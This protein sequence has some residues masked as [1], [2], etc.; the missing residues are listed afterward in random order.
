[1]SWVLVLGVLPVGWK[2]VI[3]QGSRPF[4]P[5]PY[6]EVLISWSSLLPLPA[7]SAFFSPPLL[8]AHTRGSKLILS[9]TLL[10]KKKKSLS[11]SVGL[12]LTDPSGSLQHYW[13]GNW[14]Y[15]P[16]WKTLVCVQSSLL[17]SW[18]YKVLRNA[19]ISSGIN[20]QCFRCSLMWLVPGVNNTITEKPLLLPQN[21]WEV[22]SWEEV[23]VGFSR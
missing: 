5:S 4:F 1:M 17:V 3:C 8:S 13:S 23:I 18:A 12:L 22:R 2:E 14:Y 21:K 15:Y 9:T 19:L 16:P 6:E 11:I 20:V 7:L 10:F